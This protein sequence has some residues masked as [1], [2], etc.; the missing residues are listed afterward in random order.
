MANHLKM[1]E[2]ETIVALHRQGWSKRRIARELGVDRGAVRRVLRQ[3]SQPSSGVAASPESSKAL[4]CVEVLTGSA[5]AW[6]AKPPT[7]G[8]VLTGS[9]RAGTVSGAAR[10]KCDPFRQLIEQKIAAGLSAQRIFQDL[11]AEHGFEGKYHSVQRMA[12]R[13]SAADELPFRRIEREPGAEAQADFGRGAP[14]IGLDGKRRHSH[15]LRVALSFSRK[16]YSEAFFK[17]GT[18]SWLC[19]WENAFRA[20]GGVPRTLQIDNTKSA[21]KQ[22]DWYDPEIHPIVSAFCKHYGTVLLP[23][24]IRTPR[25]NGK[26]EANVGYVKGNALKGRIF[27]TLC[28]ENE[29]L[30]QWEERVA[31]QRIH[32]TTKQQ[33][34]QLFEIEK[35]ALLP[36]P[37]ERFSFFH[38]EQRIVHRDGHIE[39]AKA[40]YSVP[41][42]YMGHTVWARWDTRLVRI[43]NSRFEQIAL[44]VR[45]ESG[46]FSTA[47][48]HLASR[49]I[50][51]V[52]QGA[53][54]LLRRARRVGP[55]T[56]RW[57][58]A[59]LKER[60]IEGVRVLVG[61]LSLLKRHSSG[62]VEHACELACAHSAFRLRALRALLKE[63]IKQEQFEFMQEHP[64]IRNLHDYG[65]LV[66]AHFN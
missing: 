52:E 35:S 10:S 39:V 4:T 61:L 25:H 55:Q 41:P 6:A 12:R 47:S 58:E 54:E 59:V 51:L 13:L 33:V 30:A 57:A 64:L 63:P 27:P 19:G 65:T 2:R 23:I 48:Q 37:A 45:N 5:P 42:E 31:D 1:A 21:V 36:L 16:G 38:E 56:G 44:H 28:A 32:G 14:I 24:K 50:A 29:H 8:Q 46:K 3:I 20:W 22:A 40:Y 62:A 43:L 11:Q 18:E 17:Q 9:E 53:T 34:R 60:S 15:V 26:A 7:P 66:G 49:K